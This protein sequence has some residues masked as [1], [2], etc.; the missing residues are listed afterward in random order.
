VRIY[1]AIDIK[2]G[3]VVRLLHGK[4]DAETVYYEDPAEPARLFKEAG[5]EWVHV[6]DLDGAFT[7][8]PQNLDAVSRIAGLG[9]K[10]QLGGGM[11]DTQT[12]QRAIDAGASRVVTGTRAC[13]D[14]AFVEEL[15]SAHKE[16]IAVGID[17]RG[18]KVA[19]HGWVDTSDRDALT[20]A[21]ALSGKGVQTLIYT[22]IATDGTL[23]GPNFRE[24]ESILHAVA[25]NVIASGGVAAR[26]DIERFAAIGRNHLNFDGVIIGKALYENRVELPDL[27][28][29]AKTG[30]PKF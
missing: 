23:T 28:E 11:R 25:A 12:V 30:Q 17:A 27:L 10:V 7:G 20:L 24:Q 8:A 6:V 13:E 18:G 2:G 5:A 21:Q 9:L 19:T 26:E 29:I 22:D 4:A 16:K 1:P 15:V 14:E 3:R